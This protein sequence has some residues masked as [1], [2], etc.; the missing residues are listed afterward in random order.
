MIRVIV[1]YENCCV[2]FALNGKELPGNVPLSEQALE[3]LPIVEL[4]EGTWVKMLTSEHDSGDPPRPR[5]EEVPT[6]LFFVGETSGPPT[7][8]KICG[9]KSSKK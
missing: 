9:G 8:Q 7:F 1:D 5:R 2:S 6:D 4:G 3:L